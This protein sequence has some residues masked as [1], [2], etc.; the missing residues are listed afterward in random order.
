MDSY[1]HSDSYNAYQQPNNNQG[2]PGINLSHSVAMYHN[3]S[4]Q[5]TQTQTSPYQ[6]ISGM[7]ASPTYSLP[8]IPSPPP[9]SLVG[10]PGPAMPNGVPRAIPPSAGPIRRRFS[11]ENNL[12]M[13]NQNRRYNTRQ[14]AMSTPYYRRRLVPSDEEDDDYLEDLPSN[15]TEQQRAEHQRHRN[16]LAA[17]RSRKRKEVYKQQLEEAVERLT[18]E[19]EKWKT[20]AEMLRSVIQSQGLPVNCGDWSE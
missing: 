4:P 3:Q 19:K 20:R 5:V 11:P 6:D 1:Y 10:L 8:H 7:P 13:D 17:R 15:A 12:P 18:V 16:T 2:V 9:H 14:A